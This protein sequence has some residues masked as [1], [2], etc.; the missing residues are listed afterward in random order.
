MR[1]GGWSR[2]TTPFVNQKFAWY[3][4]GS[5]QK[6]ALNMK[7]EYDFSDAKR[8]AVKPVKGK[9]RI[10]LYLDN[11]VLNAFRFKAQGLGL[12]LGL[13]YQTLI[14]EDLR[15]ARGRHSRW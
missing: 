9:T 11:A 2:F 4:Q 12:G 5:P 3:L 6:N 1:L 7:A 8:G 10:A 14:N 15:D 13:G